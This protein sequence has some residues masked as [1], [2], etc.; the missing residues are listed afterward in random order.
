M[1]VDGGRYTIGAIHAKVTWETLNGLTY[2]KMTYR[3]TGTRAGAGR[4]AF[5][6]VNLNS[7]SAA[8]GLRTPAQTL[9]ECFRRR[10]VRT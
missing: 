10:G 2:S 8:P 3:A 1:R 5:G 4:G 6:N 9:S 7:G